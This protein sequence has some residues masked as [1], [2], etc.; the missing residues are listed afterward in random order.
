MSDE[1]QPIV[2]TPP[3]QQPVAEPVVEAVKTGEEQ[4]TTPEAEQEKKD[5]WPDGTP[6]WVTKTVSEL[7]E[8]NRELEARL[9]AG[10][11]PVATDPNAPVD[12]DAE[13]NRRV[14][15]TVAAQTI[16]QRANKAFEL[17]SSK[18]KEE[19]SEAIGNLNTMGALF[20]DQYG[21]KPTPLGEA[22]LDSDDSHELL[23]HLGT[24]P[25]E[26]QRLMSMSPVQQAR[27]IGLLEAK[28]STQPPERAPTSNAPAPVKPVGS[29]GTVAKKA[30]DMTMEEYVAY[31]NRQ[32][33]EARKR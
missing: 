28:L 33:R 19:F 7:R 18:Y 26:A 31:R 12:I 15:E 1:N 14:A 9:N 20:Q 16:V 22:I 30:E 27:A 32:E 23:Q 13:V 8:K 3:T 5:T 4:A 17:G 10:K 25:A 21:H 29:R 6:K 11:Q 24:H 2:E